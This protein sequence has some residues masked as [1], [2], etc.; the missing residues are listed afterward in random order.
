MLLGLI[1]LLLL[2][3]LI[4]FITTPVA[5]VI[6]ARNYL[7][8]GKNGRG[9]LITG[10]F[11]LGALAS[12]FAA[13][14]LIQSQWTLPFWT[15][16]KATG[17]AEKYGNAVEHNAEGV[18]MMVIFAGVPGGAGCAGAAALGTRLLKDFAHT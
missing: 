11:I 7:L 18:I 5:F 13:W 17:D 12:A 10:F 14:Q 4:V 16:L 3:S 6:L 2:C 8:T 9:A 1:Q 15:T